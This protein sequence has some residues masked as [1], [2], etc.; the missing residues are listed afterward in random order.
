MS[1]NE[2]QSDFVMSQNELTSDLSIKSQ[3]ELKSKL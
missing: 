3:N 2:Q 1:Q